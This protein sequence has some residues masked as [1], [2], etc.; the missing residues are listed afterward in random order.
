[1]SQYK[2][3][4]LYKIQLFSDAYYVVLSR[5]SSKC[6]WVV[7]QKNIFVADLKIGMLITNRLENFFVLLH[8]L[9]PHNPKSSNW[10]ELGL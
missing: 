2:Y 6:A 8:E 4:H 9:V 1:M 3:I 10:N 7:F 5:M